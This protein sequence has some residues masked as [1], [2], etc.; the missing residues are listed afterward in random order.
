MSSS[1]FDLL[2][3][4]MGVYVLFS[5]IT[6]KGKMY[7]NENLKEGVEAQFKKTMRIVFSVLGVLML[8]NGIFP[9]L[10]GLLYT[11]EVSA[12]G[13]SVE[14]IANFDLS[15]WS[16]VTYEL[17]NTLSIVFFALTIAGIVGMF[18]VMNKFID[19]DASKKRAAND[20]RRS[21]QAMP[22]SAFDFEDDTS[23]EEN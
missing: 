1:L 21:G 7:E 16:W 23:Q 5:G 2:L 11:A 19:K 12:D 13:A 14:Y 4:A 10:S 17:L 22:N 6:G 8:L 18:I 20:P 3:L 9:L 15:D